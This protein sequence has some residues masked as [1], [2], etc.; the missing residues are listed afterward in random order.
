MKRLWE[1]FEKILIRF[2]KDFEKIM[3]RLWKDFEK[4]KEDLKRF[5]NYQFIRDDL[6]LSYL[7]TNESK[8][9]QFFVLININ[10]NYSNIFRKSHVSLRC[11]FLNILYV[12]ICSNLLHDFLDNSW[13][14]G[15]MYSINGNYFQVIVSWRCAF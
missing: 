10:G 12:C 6:V 7:F 2:W 3:K 9:W 5:K 15:S 1:D 13:M 4:I 14:R 8:R 11:V